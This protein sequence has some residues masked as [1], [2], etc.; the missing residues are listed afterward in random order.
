MRYSIRGHDV[1]KR[2]ITLQW[3]V[4]LLWIATVGLAFM[5]GRASTSTPV[6]APIPSTAPV[7]PRYVSSIPPAFIG[8]WDEIVSDGC[9]EREARYDLSPRTFSSFEVTSDVSRVKLVSPTEIELTVT[10]YNEGKSQYVDKIGFRL[11][12]DGKA[13][14]DVEEGATMY[15]RC[16]NAPSDQPEA[17]P[18]R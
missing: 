8:S 2:P 13:L 17:P 3:L 14:T 11:V 1:V 7:F 6:K 4:A 10:G 9:A 16:P 18:A 15:R 5:L 12:D